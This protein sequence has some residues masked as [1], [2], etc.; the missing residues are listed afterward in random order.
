M[1]SVKIT[2]VLGFTFVLGVT[3]EGMQFGSAIATTNSQKHTSI[4]SVN[5][6]GETYG[7]AENAA[8]NE[9]PDLIQAIGEDG[10]QGYVRAKDLE[11]EMPKTPAEALAKQRSFSSKSVRTIPLY[12][13]NGKQIGNFNVQQGNE[14]DE[15]IKMK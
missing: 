6:Y 12:D 5:K 4:F 2:F 8:Q 11:T 13:I 3:L 9:E 1:K 14:P 7:S 15:V 10:T